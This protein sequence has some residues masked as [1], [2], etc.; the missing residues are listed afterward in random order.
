VNQIQRTWNLQSA[1]LGFVT[2][3]EFPL[4]DLYRQYYF[5]KHLAAKCSD[6]FAECKEITLKDIYIDI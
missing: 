2:P 3:T 1:S 4:P 5:F 6:S